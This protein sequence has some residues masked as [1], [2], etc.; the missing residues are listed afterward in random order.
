METFY[1]YNFVNEIL[2]VL[3][4]IIYQRFIQLTGR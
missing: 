1:D 3:L 4:Q 2:V